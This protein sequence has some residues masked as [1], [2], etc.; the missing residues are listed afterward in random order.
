MATYKLNL[1][2]IQNCPRP[3][4]LA[5]AMESFG[6]PETEE[7]GVLN[8]SATD[9]AVFATIIRKTQAAIQRL[10]EQTREVTAAAV[11][12]VTVYPFAVQPSREVLEIYAGSAAG[13]EQVGTFLASCLQL[14]TIVEPIELDI[15][16]AVDKLAAD[17]RKFQLRSI[18]VSEYAHS[19]YMSGPY[20]PKFLDTQHGMDFLAEYAD[21]VTAAGVRF[22]TQ[23]GRA[24]VHLSP[25]ACFSYACGEDDTAEVQS[26]L[27]QLT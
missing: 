18:R 16:S 26:V 22:A 3:K 14:P 25:K 8:H 19:S 4:S 2:R 12:K 9:K 24:T 21:F 27:R 23:S 10:D 17:T 11:E 20:A 13:I 7:F 15:P 6:L 1:A 5:E